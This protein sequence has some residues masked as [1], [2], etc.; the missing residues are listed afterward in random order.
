MGPPSAPA[1]S[2]P[3]LFTE[4]MPY[5]KQSGGVRVALVDVDGDGGN[6][7]M[8]TSALVGNK[9]KPKTMTSVAMVTAD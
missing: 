3:K 2:P 5:G 4:F 7:L 9:V 8:T 1:A 6:E